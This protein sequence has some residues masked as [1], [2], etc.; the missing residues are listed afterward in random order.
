MVKTASTMLPLG[1]AAPDFSLP[2]V[3]GKPVS[4]KDFPGCQGLLVAFICNHCPFVVH[5][6]SEFA[7]FAREYQAKGIAVVGINSNDAAAYPADAPDKMNAEV[8]LAGYSFPYLHD[9]TQ[10]VAKAYR[11]AC[12]PDLFLFDGSLRL[13]YRGQFDDSRP[14]NGIPVTGAHLRAACDAVLAG[15]EIEDGQRPSIGCN[16]KWRP[17]NEPTYYTGQPAE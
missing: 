17:G 10:S 16:I 3:D 15:R 13:V 12:T 11:A 2:N 7:K 14:T 9:A 5:I 1:T 4:L 6:R 8:A